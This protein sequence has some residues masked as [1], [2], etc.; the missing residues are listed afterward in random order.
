MK[1]SA[2]LVI[3]LTAALLGASATPAVAAPAATPTFRHLDPGGQPRLTER[4]PVNVVFLGYDREQVDRSQFLAGLARTYQPVVQSRLYYGVTERIGI[5]YT[6]DYRLTYASRSYQDRFFQQLGT[7]AEPAPR[8]AFQDA[9]NAQASNVTDV[10]DNHYIDGPSVEKWLA[11]NPPSGVDT[12]RNTVFFINWFGRPDFKFHVYTKIGE[13]DPDTGYDFGANRDSRKMIAWGGTTADDEETGLR[14]TRRVWFHDL[15]AGP[16]STTDNYIVDEEDVDGDGVADYRMPP[17]WEYTGGGFRSPD[18]LAGDLAKLTR[19]VALDL[20]M[21]TSPVYPV[22]LPAGLPKSINLDSTTYE[23]WPGVDAS[24]EYVTPGLLLDELGELRWR[25]RLSYDNE[26]RPLTGKVLECYLAEFD[27]EEP[28]FPGQTLPP[29]ANLFLATE[30]IA[31]SLPDDAGRV[32]Y[33]LLM[34]NIAD[35]RNLPTPLGYADDDWSDGDQSYVFNFI[36]PDIVEAGYGLTTTM[37]HE[38][39]HHLGLHHPHDGYDSESGELVSAG[40]EYHYAWV[41][42]E[43]NS[44][45]SYIDVNWDFSQFDRDN[46]DRFLTAAYYEAANRLAA[47]VLADPDARRADGDLRAADVLLGLS[48]KAFAAHQYRVAY[49]LAEAAYDRVVGAAQRVG[50]D[51]AAA[52]KALRAEAEQARAATKLHSPHE[53]MDTL[54]GPR[55]RP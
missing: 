9:Y 52:A 42:D 55:G 2:A 18:A 26:D 44:M 30:E 8:T 25:N 17:I 33:E 10:T 38:A 5:T 14:S 31:D 48:R 29:V 46:S 16:E 28:C 4:V 53:F 7:L 50:A 12:R 15:S 13:P 22:E 54:D 37:I 32:D 45:M 23:G 27:T 3:A 40:G 1:R 19:Y 24:A 49:A 41:G 21:T 51:P 36:S 20:L 34:V 43:S 6:Y 47:D 11:A 35:D 39:G